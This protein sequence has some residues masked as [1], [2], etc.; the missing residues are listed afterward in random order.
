MSIPRAIT[1]R[2]I[3][4]AIL[5]VDEKGIPPRRDSDRYDLLLKGRRYPPKLVIWLAAKQATGQEWGHF[6]AVEARD[7][8]LGRNYVILDKKTG[9]SLANDEFPNDDDESASPEGA[10]RYKMHRSLERDNK[11]AR[12][13]KQRRLHQVGELRCDVCDFSFREKYG[14][15]GSRYI[16]AHHIVPVSK[17]RGTTKTKI[18]DLALVCANCHRMLHHGKPKITIET[19]SKRIKRNRLG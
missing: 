9:R 10:A 15:L 16:E 19:L 4:L 11:I 14:D 2:H 7:Y 1:A 5:E 13:A 17:L 3:R 12:K 18:D 8:F 6:N